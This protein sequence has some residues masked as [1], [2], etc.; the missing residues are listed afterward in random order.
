MKKTGRTRCPD[1][2]DRLTFTDMEL[3]DDVIEKHLH[4]CEKATSR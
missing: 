1:C 3:A 4:K 2:W